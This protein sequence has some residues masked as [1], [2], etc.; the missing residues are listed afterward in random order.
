M[1]YIYGQWNSVFIGCALICAYI[2]ILQNILQLYTRICNI[3]K[4]IYFSKNYL[5]KLTKYNHDYANIDSIIHKKNI[6]TYVKQ[7]LHRT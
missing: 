1:I 3:Y 5:E 4:Y 6:C 7:E 2:N